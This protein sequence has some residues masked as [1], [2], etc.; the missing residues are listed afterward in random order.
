MYSEI[1]NDRMLTIELYSEEWEAS[2]QNKSVHKC[3]KITSDLSVYFMEHYVLYLFI[4]S[5]VILNADVKWR[6]KL[7]GILPGLDIRGSGLLSL[8]DALML[9]QV[10]FFIYNNIHTVG[11]RKNMKTCILLNIHS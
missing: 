6:N 9:M 4:R 8:P 10:F 11:T 2:L 3:T 7:A 5:C 1:P